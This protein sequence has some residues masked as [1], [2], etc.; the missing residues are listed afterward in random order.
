MTLTVDICHLRD[1]RSYLFIS[2]LKPVYSVFGFSLLFQSNGDGPKRIPVS[3]QSKMAVVTPSPH[4]S[5]LGVSNGPKRVHRPVSHQKPVSH[6]SVVAKS[7][8][9]ADQ[10]ENPEAQKRTPAPQPKNASQQNQPK[11]N[12]PKVN[13]ET[14]KPPTEMAKQDK[15]QSK[16]CRK[17]A[18]D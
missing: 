6:V 5:V 11:I 7:T 16:R 17:L 13:T 3:Q 15:T 12:V 10:N 9:H 18:H 8:N 2:N 4:Q 14:T 1:E